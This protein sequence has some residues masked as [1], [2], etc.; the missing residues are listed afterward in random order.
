[1]EW[2][3]RE[4]RK[5]DRVRTFRPAREK[6]IMSIACVAPG[7]GDVCDLSTCSWISDNSIGHTRREKKRSPSLAVRRLCGSRSDDF[8]RYCTAIA[9]FAMPVSVTKVSLSRCVAPDPGS[10]SGSW[11]VQ[12]SVYR[13]PIHTA[14]AA[15]STQISY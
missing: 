2:R 3:L 14:S 9:A 8:D 7:I 15:R 1:M 12:G 10:D 11:S 13:T 5:T 6:H 4:N